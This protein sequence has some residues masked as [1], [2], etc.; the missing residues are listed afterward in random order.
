MRKIAII[1]LCLLL[2]VSGYSKTANISKAR[3]LA[4]HYFSKA[5]GKAAKELDNSFSVVYNG[6][7]VYHVFNYKGGGFV[8]VAA[9]DASTPILAQSDEGSIEE[10]ITNPAAKYW[11]DSYSKEIEYIITA[12]LDNTE[13]LKEWD[14]I[15]S[16]TDEHSIED[17]G[18]LLSTTWDQGEWYNYYCPAVPSG[19]GGSGGHT[20]VGCVAIAM[21]QIMKYYNFPEQGFLSHTYDHPVYGTQLANFGESTY[22]W[23]EIGNTANSSSYQDIAKLLYQSG[24]SVDMNYGP[25]ASGADQDKVP[26][27]LTTYFNYDPKSVKYVKKASYSDNEWKELLKAELHAFRPVYYGGYGSD[28][29]AWVCDGWRLS[30]DMFHMNWGWAGES[31]G[32]YRIGQLNIEF[33]G[34]FNK[35]N[36][37]IIGI[38]PGNPN[39]VVKI[40]NL[41]SN[42]LIACNSSVA[43]DCS[44]LKGTS[45]AVNIY[46]DN[47]KIYTA[48]Q[49]KFTYNLLTKDYSIGSHTIKVEAVNSSDTAFHEVTVRNSE[50]I[51]QASAF[52][53]P[54][55]GINYIHAVDTLVVW[56]IAYDGFNTNNYIHEFTR[57]V[58][59]G[60][61]WT[62][63]TITNCAA[64]VP[65][66]IFALNKDTAYCPMFKH[67][68]SN[69]PGIYQTIDG[70]AN[71]SRQVGA[72]FSDPASFPD[73]VHFFDHNNGFCM[74]DPV[75]G[76]FEIY[77][78]SNG[79]VTWN[80]VTADKIPN[81]LTDEAGVVGYYSAIGGNAWFGTTKGRVYRTNDKGLHW[82]A[83]TTSLS[84]KTVDVEFADQF[85]GLAQDKESNSAGALSET[86]DGGLTWKAVDITGQIG[87]NDFCF[88][89]GTENTWISTGIKKSTSDKGLYGVFYSLD[90]GHSWVPFVGNEND[91]MNK[92]DFVNL[93]NGW[94]SGF[95]A[96][97]AVGG[98]FRYVSKIKSK[99]FFYPVTELVAKVTGRKVNLEWKAPTTDTYSGYNVY[100]NDTLLSKISG[101]NKNY[102]DIKV[103]Y[104]KHT[105]CIEALY[106][107]GEADAICADALIMSPVKNL[108]ATVNDKCV[109]LN[110]D[111]PAITVGEFDVFYNVYRNDTLLNKYP[112]N[113]GTSSGDCPYIPLT[114]GK[115]TYCVVAIY[116][117]IE[118][119]PVCTDAWIPTGIPENRLDVKVYPN[120]ANEFIMIETSQNFS[121]VSLSNLLGQEV[122]CYCSNGNILK[123]STLGFQPG[124]YVLQINFGNNTD[125]RKISIF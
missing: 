37:A 74:G 59:G 101:D 39:L 49:S 75:G 60:K 41:N 80:R 12:K 122:Y 9:T 69:L 70:G 15:L 56:A 51:S 91:Q 65:S 96:N 104:G 66:M 110:W 106:P 27:A 117:S 64:L 99:K 13:T 20:L 7:T 21:G 43:I 124:I 94:A 111:R 54:S 2:T 14:R 120:P 109:S 17:A 125:T 88:V 63:D 103:S 10:N 1:I 29:H 23:G 44:V 22:N 25:G 48:A 58:D 8:V 68:G 67:S 87:T 57:T 24:V 98:M 62:S 81:P 26:W 35:D 84:G 18:P 92:V 19:S 50:W 61:T 71:W 31:D 45:D 77:T 55:R 52:P 123:I 53:K 90:G 33:Q 97:A 113:V 105:Y 3:T 107:T 100:R 115:K 4:D 108:I 118:S 5:S 79:G 6:I 73:V 16:K 78:T 36:E 89:P 47:N 85:H 83:S 112:F 28:G 102:N 46:I 38:R 30:D 42:Q 82:E 40:T 11:L 34:E 116:N 121:E 86:F 32:W 119:E 76:E 93:R 114:S 72:S 95:N